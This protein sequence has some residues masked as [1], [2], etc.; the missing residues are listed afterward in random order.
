MDDLGVQAQL[1]ATL[2]LRRRLGS[3]SSAGR[4]P[5]MYSAGTAMRRTDLRRAKFLLRTAL[6]MTNQVVVITLA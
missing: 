3:S 4:S 6:E 5:G 1:S 2:R